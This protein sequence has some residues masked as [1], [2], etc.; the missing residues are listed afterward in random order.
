MTDTENG[1]ALAMVH[2]LRELVVQLNL[3]GSEFARLA[4]ATESHV[5]PW[6]TEQEFIYCYC[7]M[8]A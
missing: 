3:F 5:T 7:R 6:G 4:S 1:R 8:P 2:A